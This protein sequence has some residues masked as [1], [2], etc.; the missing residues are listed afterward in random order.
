M[1]HIAMERFAHVGVNVEE[2]ETIS[3]PSMTFTQDAIRRL[4]K[5]K[6]FS[7]QKSAKTERC[8]DLP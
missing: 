7:A 3:R 4:I 5:N 8:R 2:R 6:M 1:E